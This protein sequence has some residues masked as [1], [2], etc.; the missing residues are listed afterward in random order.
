MLSHSSN[1]SADQQKVAADQKQLQTDVTAEQNTIAADRKASQPT[2]Q[3][4][5]KQVQTDQKAAGG[6][7]LFWWQNFLYRRQPAYWGFHLGQ[8]YKPGSPIT[9]T[10][11]IGTPI[12]G[13]PVP[14]PIP[15]DPIVAYSP[16]ANPVPLVNSREIVH[17]PGDALKS[18]GRA[19]R[20][21]SERHGCAGQCIE[22]A[23][24]IRTRVHRTI[25]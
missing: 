12:I 5:L 15:V 23:G 13:T 16:V 4:D 25:Y 24:R 3:A 7:G 20:G 10:P 18:P 19:G 11:V 6:G 1:V 22:F 17:L 21:F 14:G 2:I 9:G 8:L